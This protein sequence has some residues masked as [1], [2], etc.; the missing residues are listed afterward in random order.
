[1]N[2]FSKKF[3]TLKREKKWNQEKKF[4]FILKEKDNMI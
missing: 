3:L 1:M 2:N 4:N